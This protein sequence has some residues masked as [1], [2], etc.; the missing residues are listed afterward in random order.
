MQ[1]TKTQNSPIGI[2]DSGVGGLTIAHAISNL[3]PK[4]SIIYFGDSAHLPYGDKSATTIIHY[5]QRIVD[6]LLAQ[7]CKLILIACNSASSAAYD[8]LTSYI[9]SRAILLNVIDP[10][11]KH[12]NANLA[13][14]NIG[15]IGTKQTIS[16]KAY[17][18]KIAALNKNIKVR[19][20]ATPLLTPAIE[21]NFSTHKIIDAIISEYLSRGELQNIDALILACTHYPI[22]KD[23]ISAF[24]NNK[25]DIINSTEI[26]AHSVKQQLADN[27]L[28]SANN[29]A[30]HRFYVS[31]LTES[32]QHKAGMFF[33][34]SINL[35]LYR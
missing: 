14:K 20:L 28:L 21:E 35:K 15:I 5:S 7:N 27:N 9:G 4:E 8:T 23:R 1:H 31:D 29:N 10:I 24:Y 6:F 16:S 17:Q 19:G 2:F 32:F 18:D 11:I 25:I 22:I 3:L 34:D 12:I 33:G 13:K 26:I 30:Q